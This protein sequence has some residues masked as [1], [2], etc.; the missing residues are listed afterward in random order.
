MDKKRANKLIQ[1]LKIQ[2]KLINALGSQFW[3]EEGAL[4]NAN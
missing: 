1:T 4:K 2:R 3:Y